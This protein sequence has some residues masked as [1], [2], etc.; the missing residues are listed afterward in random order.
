MK[1]LDLSP[2]D[3]VIGK[4]PEGLELRQAYPIRDSVAN[5]LFAQP[6]LKARDLLRRDDIAR[7]VIAAPDDNVEL[8]DAEFTQLKT[9]VDSLD[10]Y[11]RQDVELIRRIVALDTPPSA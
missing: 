6:G 5:I 8:D 10:G 11:G 9:A 7:K 4:T 3:V 1:T 2:Y